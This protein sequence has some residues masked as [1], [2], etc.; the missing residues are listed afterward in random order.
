MHWF[1]LSTN[2]LLQSDPMLT[3][4]QLTRTATSPETDEDTKSDGKENGEERFHT[5]EVPNDIPNDIQNDD[6]PKL[7]D[8]EIE[9]NPAYIPRKGRYYMHDSREA[10]EE[11]EEKRTSRAD[12][13]WKHDRYN[14]RFQRPKTKKQIMTRY[15]FDIRERD[16]QDA[17]PIKNNGQKRF[18]KKENDDAE[19]PVR[20]KR[21]PKKEPRQ[22]QRARYERSYEATT[23][24]RSQNVDK[25]GRQSGHRSSAEDD[26]REDQSANQGRGDEDDDDLHV[27]QRRQVRP[28]HRRE[29]HDRLDIRVVRNVRGSRG[30]LGGHRMD[31]HQQQIRERLDRDRYR[32]QNG[33]RALYQK[34]QHLGEQRNYEN[35]RRGA[36]RGT[37]RGGGNSYGPPR[38]GQQIRTFAASNRPNDLRDAGYQREDVPPQRNAGYSPRAL[39]AGNYYDTRGGYAPRGN[40]S[41]RSRGGISQSPRGAFDVF[42]SRG[43]TGPK[44]YSEQRGEILPSQAPI[45]V[46]PPI[47]PPQHN[48]NIPRQPT[49]VVYFDPTQQPS[50]QPLPP[51]EKKIIEIVPPSTEDNSRHTHLLGDSPH[52]PLRFETSV[53]ISVNS[54]YYSQKTCSDTTYASFLSKTETK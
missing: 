15:G 26:R 27:G 38:G 41:N 50:R 36:M 54:S 46:P 37:I 39:D 12:G 29:R 10:D 25:P 45:T 2:I 18:S 51:R 40:Y 35:H 17:E 52:I 48:F 28:E 31:R 49:D 20:G 43:F 24:P 22:K 4:K 3:R 13:T 23:K 5:P 11:V 33:D 42:P 8:D 47:P 30:G 1:V 16:N 7:D 14:E 9:G 21:R 6:E 34:E 32:D 19:E 44:R 53:D